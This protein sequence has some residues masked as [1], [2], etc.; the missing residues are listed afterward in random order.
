[1][2][3]KEWKEPALTVFGDVFELTHAAG[4]FTQDGIV[5]GSEII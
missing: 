3:K 1:M 4:T 2:D 5:I